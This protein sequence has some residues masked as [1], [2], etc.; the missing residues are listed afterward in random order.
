MR[1]P[2][3][4]GIPGRPRRGHGERGQATVE[5]ALLLPLALAVLL[6][7]VQ[8]GL[9]VRDQIAVVHAAREAARAAAVDPNPKRAEAAARQVVGGADVDVR[10]RGSVGEPVVVRVRYRSITDLPMVGPLIPD[11]VLEAEATMRVER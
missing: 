9:I 1:H 2:G 10:R 4:N 5:F 11:P 3:V 8:A 7:I 6:A